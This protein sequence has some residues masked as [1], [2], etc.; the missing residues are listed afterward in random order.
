MCYSITTVACL[1]PQAIAMFTIS[2]WVTCK[3]IATFVI[4]SWVM[5]RCRSLGNPNANRYKNYKRCDNLRREDNNIYFADRFWWEDN[6]IFVFWIIWFCRNPTTKCF[7][8]PTTL[9]TKYAEIELSRKKVLPL[10][11]DSVIRQ[12]VLFCLFLNTYTLYISIAT[13]NNG[14]VG[15]LERETRIGPPYPNA[16]C[17]RRLKLGGF[18][19]QP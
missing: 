12:S 6:H 3:F 15:T 5:C 19:E 14:P 10:Y 9:Y 4:G 2:L 17:K 1:E 18:S 8:F 16:R 13:T 7:F 11:L